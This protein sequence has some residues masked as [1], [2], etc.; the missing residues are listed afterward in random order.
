M[1]DILYSRKFL[2]CNRKKKGNLQRVKIRAAASRSK[3][4]GKIV[5]PF[6]GIRK[7]HLSLKISC[8]V[9]CLLPQSIIISFLHLFNRSN[10]AHLPKRAGD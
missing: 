1:W 6:Q 9:D 5:N 3:L 8:Y 7:L 2:S 10:L 4:N